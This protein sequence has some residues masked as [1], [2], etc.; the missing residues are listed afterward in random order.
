MSDYQDSG[1]RSRVLGTRFLLCLVAVLSLQGGW[2]ERAVGQSPASPNQSTPV[3]W[4]IFDL[5]AAAAAITGFEVGY[6]RINDP[7]PAQT[8]DVP[9]SQV[10][11]VGANRVR[12]GLTPPKLPA[13]Q[14]FIVR[15]RSIAGDRRGY[16]S[17]HAGILVGPEFTSAA[18]PP[19][20]TSNARV[21]RP[22]G[23]VRTA[24]SDLES[25]PALR[26]RLAAAFPR[27]DLAK[28]AVGYRTVRDLATVLYAAS[29]LGIPFDEL[30]R[31]TADERWNLRK[32]IA[33]L[34][35]R[36]D[37]RAEARK[38]QSQSLELVRGSTPH[39]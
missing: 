3:R 6:F 5:P 19:R 1:A 23:A 9:R 8:F 12:L 16:W 28:A 14:R 30:R 10:E 20:S 21:R 35:P 4:L 33:T 32:A 22:P 25:D 17:E 2:V 26:A 27:V 11:T 13:D 38:A 39:R 31:L 24:Q 29:N 18:P 34:R 36:V 7:I 37:A 15:V